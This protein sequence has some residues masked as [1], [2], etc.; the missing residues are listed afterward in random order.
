MIKQIKF[1]QSPLLKFWKQK[2]R[3]D[4]GLI[5]ISTIKEKEKS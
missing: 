5:L 1:H 3:M 2:G 4:E